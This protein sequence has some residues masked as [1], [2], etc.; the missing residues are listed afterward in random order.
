MIFH[1][2]L[3]FSNA[4]N[5]IPQYNGSL[6]LLPASLLSSPQ[7]PNQFNKPITATSKYRFLV[8]FFSLVLQSAAIT[9][10]ILLAMLPPPS[11]LACSFSQFSPYYI[12]LHTNTHITHIFISGRSITSNIPPAFLTPSCSYLHHHH[13]CL[14]LPSTAA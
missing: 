7:P 8:S 9:L 13:C 12:I 4:G 5:S 14:R 1:H 2:L 3:L 10:V 6:S 11:R